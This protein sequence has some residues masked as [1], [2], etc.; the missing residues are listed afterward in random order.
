[1][2]KAPIPTIVGGGI[3][4]V[5]GV[6]GQIGEYFFVS[7]IIPPEGTTS[8]RLRIVAGAPQTIIMETAAGRGDTVI[9]PGST[10]TV[11]TTAP[12]VLI[13][14]NITSVAAGSPAANIG[15][16]ENIG[17]TAASSN[18]V[19]IGQMTAGLFPVGGTTGGTNV[20]V[21]RVVSVGGAFRN[22]VAAL[23]SLTTISASNTVVI[24]QSASV[25]GADAIVIGSAANTG[26]GGNVIIGSAAGASGARSICIGQAVTGTGSTT[27]L[28]A[29]GANIGVAN[30]SQIIAIGGGVSVSGLAAGDIIIGHNNNG[31]GGFSSRVVWGGANL[32]TNVTPVPAWTFRHKN[33][34]GADTA[35]GSVTFI[36]PLATGNAAGGSF[37]FQTGPAGASGAAL[38]AATTRL[39]ISPNGV[40]TFATPTAAAENIVIEGFG[41][42]GQASIR[43]NNLTNGAGVG[44]GTLFNAPTAGDPAFWI[45]VN[46]AGAVRF[47]PAWP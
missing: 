13:G 34:Q 20:I 42:A 43:L 6:V 15:I 23:G 19:F 40:S 3:A 39:T 7:S 8:P 27:D 37:I 21:G 47:I 30:L 18:N 44:A 11:T 46:I 17:F 25:S 45:P 9:G 32:H 24:G 2:G 31:G 10:N 1:M 12:P 29:L 41:G 33:A 4:L 38:Q 36:A 26:G 5:P 28:I 35:A 22:G 16:G 14:Q